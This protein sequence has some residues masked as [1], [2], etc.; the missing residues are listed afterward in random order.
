M[1]NLFSFFLLLTSILSFLLGIF[2]FFK[3]R[4]SKLNVLWSVLSF[5]TFIWGFSLFKIIISES[6]F[7]TIFWNKV[8][9]M[10][11]IFIPIFYYHF[12][13]TLLNIQNKR[14]F[15]INL[16]YIFG[17]LFLFFN[18][19]KLFFKELPDKYGLEYWYFVE[20]GFIYHI[21]VLFF[22]FL[23]IFSFYDLI[24]EY[25]NLKGH[26][27]NQVKYV[28]FAGIV[29]F[30][31]GATNFLPQL[32]KIYPFGNFFVVFYIVVISYAIVKHRLMDIRLVISKSILYFILVSTVAMV[33]TTA[34]F[35]TGNIFVSDSNFSKIGVSLF[36][37]LVIVLALDPLKRLLAKWTDNV[38]YKGKINYQLVLRN[39]G[40]IIAK[41]IDLDKLLV[42]L[43]QEIGKSL[44]CKDVDFLYM[45]NGSKI[46]RG[47]LNKDLL[48]TQREDLVQYLEEN[49]DIII[50][51]ELKRR[52]SEAKY[53]S[54]GY[55]S[56]LVKRLNNVN[57][58]LI[59]PIISENKLIC[60][61]VIK[62][63]L[64]GDIFSNQDIDAIS[65][66]TPQI[67][68]ALEKS[69]LYEEI[70]SFNI[71]LQEKVDQAT[72]DL[73][74]VNVD[75][76]TRN[77]YLS[78]LQ[79]ISSKITRSLNF[80]EVIQFIATSIG[81]ELGFV[82]GVINFID[83]RKK[84]IYI[85]A[86]SHSEEINQAISFL[87]ANPKDY[88]VSLAEEYN[89]AVKSINRGTI[90]KTDQLFDV[91]K[92]AIKSEQAKQIQKTLGINS[93]ISV[94]IYSE[95]KIIGSID[96]FSSEKLESIKNIDIEVMRSLTDQA[97]LVIRNLKL[98]QELS[99]KNLQLEDAN[100]HLKKLDEA[101][102]EFLSIASH[103]LRTPLTGIKGYL[104]MMLEGDYGKFDK[105]QKIILGDVFDASDRM[106]RLVNVFL[107]VSRIESGRF[108][109]DKASIDIKDLI[110]KIIKDLELN[111]KEKGLKLSFK[112]CRSM[113]NKMH[114]V[115]VD[116]DKLK[117]VLINLIDNSIK[118]TSKGSVKVELCNDDEN[119]IVKVKDTGVG[120]G[121]GESKKLFNKFSRGNDIARID[122]T[123]SGLGLYIARKIIEAHGGRIWVESKGL[124][125]GSI[126][127]FTLP[128]K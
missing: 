111:A 3:N 93:I 43:S 64:S 57:A 48:L 16:S 89:I 4:K 117:D 91:F 6:N 82:G 72:G 30:G 53:N 115:E 126:F 97:G 118:Y 110:L 114:Q 69:K 56:A 35:V 37:S 65:V 31:G 41:E 12:V 61:L 100:V 13:I 21:F 50:T 52:A 55:L 87:E 76:A 73:K 121:K 24:R 85:K 86:L 70:Q 123:G 116:A 108:K 29:G 26:K 66:I 119:I 77:R 94:P 75:L 25:K 1:F 28:L 46:Y 109:L 23:V 40:K 90:Q 54:Q 33:F 45:S 60:I 107:N 120:L 7:E 113:A 80:K 81:T 128:L 71:K 58:G 102:S 125:K 15:I 44:K 98:Y 78:A 95:N 103:Q 10:G 112:E 127:Q 39:L 9:Y 34:T 122:T 83:E 62:E 104:S 22:L 18:F 88:R 27:K 20:V 2:L 14:K 38:F 59:A 101:K 63:K 36:V 8:L 51:A 74:R 11:A 19:T 67:A 68:N 105:K 47:I 5:C 17:F 49:R 99:K 96:F 106:T 84:E 79:R 124:G 92:P 32:F 42:N